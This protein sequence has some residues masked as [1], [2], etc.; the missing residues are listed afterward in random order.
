MDETSVLSDM[1]SSSTV[2]K[3]GSKTVTLNSTWHEEIR[4]SV[5]LTAQGNGKM[6]NAS[7]LKE[8]SEK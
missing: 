8:P 5:C 1:G 7:C 4:I 6:L 2:D 3:T